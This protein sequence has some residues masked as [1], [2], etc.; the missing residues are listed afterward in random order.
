MKMAQKIL[1]LK[2]CTHPGLEFIE[3][4]I[5]EA[6]QNEDCQIEIFEPRPLAQ[7]ACENLD[8]KFKSA[9]TFRELLDIAKV[10]LQRMIPRIVKERQ[11]DSVFF[12]NGEW[13]VEPLFNELHDLKVKVAGWMVDDPY[14]SNFSLKVG[15]YCDFVFT[16]EKNMLAAYK[17]EA[18]KV[19]IFLPLGINPQIHKKISPVPAQFQSSISHIGFPFPGSYRVE[20]IK[21]VLREFIEEKITIIGAGFGHTWAEFLKGE[22]PAPKIKEAVFDKWV[23][24]DEFARYVNGTQIF[25]NIH[26][27][28]FELE[29]FSY[30]RRKI[31]S[32]SP[33]EKVF[34]VAGCG[35][36]QIVDDRRPYLAEFFEIGREIVTFS[37]FADLKEKIKFYLKHPDERQKIADRAYEKVHRQHTYDRRIKK[38]LEVITR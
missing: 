10:G 7:K 25:L 1:I 21:E 16:V 34:A 17:K 36:F 2:K 31:A 30:N 35:T 28:D 29:N 15:Q 12:I 8:E 27:D 38:I 18:G 32:L 19:A 37:S 9:F 14:I 22:V 20:I 33:A 13:L 4:S 3:N 24:I 11:V 5:V 23:G 26:R 6:F